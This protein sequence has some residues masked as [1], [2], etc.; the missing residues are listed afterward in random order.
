[1]QSILLQARCNHLDAAEK[2]PSSQPPVQQALSLHPFKNFIANTKH[3][4]LVEQTK[5]CIFYPIFEVIFT[6]IYVS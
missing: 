3:Q 2:L 4:W 6:E 5:F 1:M